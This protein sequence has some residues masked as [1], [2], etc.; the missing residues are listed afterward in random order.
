[1]RSMCRAILLMRA[2]GTEAL[3]MMRAGSILK[4][5]CA[6]DGNGDV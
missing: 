2:V 3:L 1:V 4:R 5:V 6:S